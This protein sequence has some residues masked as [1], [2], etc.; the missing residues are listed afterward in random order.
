MN[1]NNPYNFTYLDKLIHGE[2]K[3]LELEHDITI[4]E[5]EKEKFSEGITVDVNDIEINGNGY[6]IDSQGLTRIFKTTGKNITLKNITFKNGYSKDSGAAIA[7]VG[8]VKIYNSNFTD[9]I[10]EVDGG[11]VYNDIN[12]TMTI[13]DSILSNNS[14]LTDGGAIFNWGNLTI[15]CSVI[16]ENLSWE[17][18]G[19]IH[20]GGLTHKTSTINELEHYMDIDLSN[21]KVLIEDT[22][23]RHNT[24][25]H[26]GGGIINWATLDIK[27]STFQDNATTERGGAVNNQANGIVTITDSNLIF[28]KAYFTGG[29]I[30]NQK[31]G[32]IIITDSKIE[33]NTTRG[34]GGTISNRGLI[35]INKST[36][37]HN[38]AIPNGGVI[39][40]SGQANIN[41]SIFGYNKAHENGGAI[42][43]SGHV[44]INNSL[45]KE[46][47]ANHW[48][49]SIY[50]IEGKISLTDT[51]IMNDIANSEE[52]LIESIHNNKGS[53]II[54]DTQNPTINVYTRE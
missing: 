20:N 51:E 43:N 13:Q 24:G 41:K 29:A 46:N 18:A 53:I 22:I 54:M 36:F 6:S 31:N 30:N 33:N 49:D 52:N 10:A 34:Y 45:F 17:D 3:E 16:E 1:Y 8:S 12:G 4:E 19:A 2:H 9:N 21:V 27:N 42:L 48:G 15:K 50:N 7:N 11:A 37:H 28:N 44:N 40:N 23:I 38:I 32:T 5:G 35:E 14:A 47:T 25:N 39:Y 26:S